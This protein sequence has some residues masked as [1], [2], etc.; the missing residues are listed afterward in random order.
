MVKLKSVLEDL[1]RKLIQLPSRMEYAK[2]V[3][4]ELCPWPIYIYT[5]GGYTW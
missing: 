5:Q 2:L 1:T 4:I 3:K